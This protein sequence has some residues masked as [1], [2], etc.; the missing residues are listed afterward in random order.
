M[1][2]RTTKALV[3]PLLVLTASAYAGADGSAWV[4]ETTMDP[5]TYQPVAVLHQASGNSIGDE[6]RS[7]EVSPR[8]EFRCVPGAG[9][10]VKV[11]IDWQR[12]IS[13]FNTEVTFATDEAEP[14]TVKLGV[15]RSNK[16]TMTKGAEDDAALLDYLSGGDALA[17][18]VTPY[19]EV[20][21]TVHY[22]LAGIDEELAKLEASC[23]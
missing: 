11:R 20:P 21:V 15:D 23:N 8:L 18:T 22:S 9:E 5:A 19:S 1:H 3:A 10:D 7:K 17:V 6:Y 14:L 4:L 12:F 2:K 13:S 16:I